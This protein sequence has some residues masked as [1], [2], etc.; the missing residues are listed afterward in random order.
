MNATQVRA[1]PLKTFLVLG[2]P[3][4]GKSTLAACC[5]LEAAEGNPHAVFWLH[6]GAHLAAHGSDAV[7]ALDLELEV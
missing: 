3:C 7:R 5:A 6:C 1:R 4:V 2:E